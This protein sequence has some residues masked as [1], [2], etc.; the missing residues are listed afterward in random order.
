MTALQAAFDHIA[1]EPATKVVVLN[2][3]GRGRAAL[4]QNGKS[5]D[6]GNTS[7]TDTSCNQLI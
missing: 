7:D 2:G 6:R 1:T 4:S 3:A 5:S